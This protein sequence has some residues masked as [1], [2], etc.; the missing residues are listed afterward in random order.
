MA[1]GGTS[2]SGL[3]PK[4]LTGERALRQPEDLKHATLLPRP[5]P[6]MIGVFG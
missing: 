5:A 1:D 6:S 2:V 3:Q 4:L